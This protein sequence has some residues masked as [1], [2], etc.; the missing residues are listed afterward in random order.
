MAQV[1]GLLFQN[2]RN[3]MEAQQFN[4]RETG[5][6]FMR[7]AFESQS[8]IQTLYKKFE[9]LAKEY[10]LT[11]R[12]RSAEHKQRVLLLVSKFDHCLGDLLYRARIGELK[13]DA[14]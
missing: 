4:D 11:W 12:M 5:L 9:P 7:V 1:T 10:E 2:G 6:F 3:I 14:A 8:D 13:M